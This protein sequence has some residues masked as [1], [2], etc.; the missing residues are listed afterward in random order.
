MSGD[1]PLPRGPEPTPWYRMLPA[2]LAAVV[3]FLVALTTL[4]GNVLELFDKTAPPAPTA[5][6]AAPPVAA[7][8][9]EPQPQAPLP[10]LSLELER[11]VVRADGGIGA[12]DWRFTIQ[13]DGNPL[14]SFPVDDLDD[15]GG[16]NVA[17]M[18]DLRARLRLAAD[19]RA[20]ITVEGWRSSRF[21][22]GHAAPDARGE[23]VLHG[24]GTIAAVAVEAADP[25]DGAF[26]FQFSAGREA[27]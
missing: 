19:A 16:R 20:T 11:I 14:L 7:S 6:A 23:G 15:G 1:A 4:A 24:D 10:P 2:Q 8:A 18:H 5:P 9:P 26:T 21:R 12:T 13:A 3:V 22:G 27:R 25:S 17:A